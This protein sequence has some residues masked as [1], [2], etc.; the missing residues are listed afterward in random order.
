MHIYPFAKTFQLNTKNLTLPIINPDNTCHEEYF[1]TINNLL[2]NGAFQQQNHLHYYLYQIKHNRHMQLG[3]LG[4]IAIK[5]FSNGSIRGHEATSI[6][7]VNDIIYWTSKMNTQLAPV[8]LIY[9]DNNEL[10]TLFAKLT[11]NSPYYTIV[12]INNI[13]HSLWLITNTT[14]IELITNAFYQINSFYVADGH[15]RIAAKIKMVKAQPNLN[16]NHPKNSIFAALF[17][18]TQVY[19]NSQSLLHIS[20][21][22][23]LDLIDHGLA[24]APK[25]TCFEIKPAP[26][27]VIYPYYGGKPASLPLT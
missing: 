10:S 8:K 6:A 4:K 9:R 3:V 5:E 18:H 23:I 15:H 16:P 26:W 17:P 20:T 21:E 11:L 7:R 12:D 14:E 25:S 13:Q 24:L 22:R 1:A 2:T 27:L 19:L